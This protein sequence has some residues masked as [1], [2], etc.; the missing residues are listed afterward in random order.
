MKAFLLIFLLR[1]G[2]GAAV[3]VGQETTEY[4]APT[5]SVTVLRG[6]TTLC[7]SESPM[8]GNRG[9][10]FIQLG[11]GKCPQRP[12]GSVG[13]GWDR[14]EEETV[15]PGIPFKGRGL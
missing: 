11:K 13:V 10:S 1:F 7:R 3:P 8:G 5:E 6:S 12:A 15:S 14:P 9:L 4:V 2:A